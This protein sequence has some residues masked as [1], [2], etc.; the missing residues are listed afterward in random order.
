MPKVNKLVEVL[1]KAEYAVGMTEQARDSV[2]HPGGLWYHAIGMF[3]AFYS[4]NE[5]LKIRL[6]N[7]GDTDLKN[8]VEDWWKANEA[9]VKGFFGNARNV[10]THQGEI[11]CEYFTWWEA[12]D[13]NDTRHP[14]RSAMVTVKDSSIENM[15]AVDFLDLCSKAL[16]FM[17][18]GILTINADYKSRGGTKHALPEPDD[19]SQMLKG[20]SL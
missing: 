20:I 15:P 17:R 1:A 18:D 4:I 19:L 5:E 16:T 10:A 7:G 6:K 12:D 11:V 8:A 14:F 3:N 2:H 9:T 13:W